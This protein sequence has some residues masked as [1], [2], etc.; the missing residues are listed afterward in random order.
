MTR[1]VPTSTAPA[2]AP[3]T[4]G[5]PGTP[6]TPGTPGTPGTPPTD[7]APVRWW[8]SLR[9]RIA[10]AVAAVTIGA[11]LITGAMVDTTAAL[12]SRERLRSQALDRLDAAVVF[13]QSRNTLRFGAA[14]DSTELPADMV[15]AIEPGQRVTQYDGETMR[16]AQRIDSQHVL[17]VAMPGDELR[18][19]RTELRLAWGSA[20]LVGV[21]FATLSGWLVGTWLSRRLRAGAQAAVAITAGRTDL[22]AGQPGHDEVAQLTSAVDQMAAALQRRLEIERQ[23]TADVAHELR[24]PVTALVSAAELLPDDELGSLLRRQAGRLRRLVIDLLEISR[25]DTATVPIEWEDRHLGAL[26]A[27]AL[28]AFDDADEPV[29]FVERDPAVVRVEP[30]RVDRIVSN[31]VRNA[32]IHGQHPI[33]VA[34]RGPSITVSD[35]GDGYPAELI[36]DGPQRFATYA[37][38]KGSGL[39]LTIADKQARA[40]G[41]RLELTNG[42]PELGGANATVVLQ[43][44]E[45]VTEPRSLGGAC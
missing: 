31:L 43:P 42:T 16:A 39:G 18:A 28:D 5:N 10:L 3:G 24:S 21:A 20:A 7:V 2:T 19:Q 17:S 32:R 34:V 15:E 25:L 13:Y 6:T 44:V 35:S 36:D 37:R 33:R 1:A 40:M 26:V 38:G 41:G 45:A 9:T 27:S 12:D 29:E 14:I 4:P 22:T 30:R 11:S 8:H 23:F